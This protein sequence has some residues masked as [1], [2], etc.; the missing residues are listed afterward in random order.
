MLVS[1]PIIRVFPNIN[2]AFQIRI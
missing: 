1:N 2:P